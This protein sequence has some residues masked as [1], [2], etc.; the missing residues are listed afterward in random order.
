MTEFQIIFAFLG[1]MAFA[2]VSIFL[3][4]NHFANRETAKFMALPMYR[5]KPMQSGAWALQRRCP[6]R[7]YGFVAE[8]KD[9]A[10]AKEIIANLARDCV[11]LEG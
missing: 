11:N 6:I 7:G 9:E 5:L 3:S 2:G 4:A 10:E 8:V 1:V